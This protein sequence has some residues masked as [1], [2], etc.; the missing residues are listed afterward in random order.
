M[1]VKVQVSI[2]TTFPTPRVLVYNK[3]RS[4]TYEGGINADMIKVLAGRPKAYFKAKMTPEGL[5]IDEEV[6]AQDW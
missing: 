4:F 3:D 6:P 2:V 5:E 1:I